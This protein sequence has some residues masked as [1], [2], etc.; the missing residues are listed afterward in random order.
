M[1]ILKVYKFRLYP[2]NEQKGFFEQTFR[3]VRFIY[4]K[5]LEDKIEHYKA[6]KE[7]LYNTPSQYKKKI[8]F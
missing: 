3:N 8:I 7:K 1:R 4:N 6:T 5:M 2:N